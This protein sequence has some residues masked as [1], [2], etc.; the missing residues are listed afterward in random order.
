MTDKF[1]KME[2]F[3]FLNDPTFFSRTGLA[4]RQMPEGGLRGFHIF[5]YVYYTVLSSYFSV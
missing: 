4:T 5:R 2:F 1:A 3:Q